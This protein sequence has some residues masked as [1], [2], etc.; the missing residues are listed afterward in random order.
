VDVPRQLN[1]DKP[2]GEP[3]YIDLEKHG[4]KVV[5]VDIR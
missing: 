4:E 1:L 5:V 2:A 3:L